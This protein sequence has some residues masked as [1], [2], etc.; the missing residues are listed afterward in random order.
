[1][2][3]YVFLW[4]G[5][6]VLF[7]FSTMAVN[8]EEE[9]DLD[10]QRSLDDFGVYT[11][12]LTATGKHNFTVRIG[13]NEVRYY[14]NAAFI[15]D[16]LIYVYGYVNDRQSASYY[17]AWLWVLDAAG[18]TLYSRVMQWGELSEIVNVLKFEEGWMFIVEESSIDNDNY[19][20]QHTHLIVFDPYYAQYQSAALDFQ[21]VRTYYEDNRWFLSRQYHG[22]YSLA[23]NYDLDF[24]WADELIGVTAYQEFYGSV[25]IEFINSVL[26]NGERYINGAVI[27]YPGHYILQ[28]DE[29][30]IPFTVHPEIIGIVDGLQTSQAVAFDLSQGQLFLNDELYVSNTLI[31]QPG[32]YTFKVKG[33][34][35]Y[36]YSLSF[37]ID[38][39]LQGVLHNQVY[40]SPR[41]LIFNGQGYLNHRPLRSG[42]VISEEGIY[43][44]DIYGVNGYHEHHRFHII[45][46]EET[47]VNNTIWIYQGA[48]IGVLVLLLSYIGYHKFL[49]K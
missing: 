26:I 43:A 23:V 28:F 21:I 27:D 5:L 39:N 45:T 17:Q 11:F 18:N 42:T 44:L 47:S 10:Y 25:T 12:E 46:E 29:Q 15:N 8:A 20:F 1:M 9:T 16:E 40:A 41:T 49:K 31:D 32:H 4:L 3:R 24:F 33:I 22:H 36:E 34:N 48:L 6:G 35:H 14:A 37:T 19:Q 38:A 13:C 7:A 30:V 2:K